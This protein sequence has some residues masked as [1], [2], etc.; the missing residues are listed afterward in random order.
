MLKLKVNTILLI[1][2]IT[3]FNS[4]AIIHGARYKCEMKSV[5]RCHF[6]NLMLTRDDYKIEPVADNPSAVKVIKLFGIVPVLSS[7]EICE[8]FPNLEFFF[9]QRLS[10]EEIKEGAFQGCKNVC[11]LSLHNN[12][13]MQLD[14]NVFKGLSNLKEL[15]LYSNHLFD[16]G[17]ENLLQHTPILS[18]IGLND[19]NFKCSRITE[20]LNLLKAKNIEAVEG[21]AE[22]RKRDYTPKFLLLI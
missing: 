10:M 12:N 11:Y 9:A 19:N 14:G 17:V 20:I 2:V 6:H 15:R 13:L 22:L 1:L 4:C 8:A 5:F 18:K 21:T 16:L 7:S 3:L